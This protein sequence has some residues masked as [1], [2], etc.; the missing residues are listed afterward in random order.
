MHDIEPF[1]RWRDYYIA[2]E[3]EASP[4]HGREYSEFQYSQKIYNYFIHPQWDSIGSSTLYLKILFVDYNDGFA[5]LELIGEW[6]D[7]LHNDIA[8]LK[9]NL[10]DHL[11]GQGIN[12]FILA[13]ENVLN[14]HGGDEDYYEEWYEDVVE[15]QGWVALLNLQDHVLQEMQEARLQHYLYISPFLND[16]NWRILKPKMLLNLIQTSLDQMPRQLTY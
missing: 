16:V 15:E 2:S 9:R 10:I 7:C 14:F 5:V 11:L 4:F 8:I 3:D 13:C 1:Y 12:K 6:N